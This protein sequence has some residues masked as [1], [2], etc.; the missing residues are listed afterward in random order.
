[1]LGA[2]G[3]LLAHAADRPPWADA[4]CGPLWVKPHAGGEG[5]TRMKIFVLL[6]S[7]IGV[8]LG[9]LW[10]LQG[11]GLL[12]VRPIL[13]FADCEPVQGPSSTWAIVGLLVVTGGILGV[14]YSLKHRARL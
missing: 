4:P 1:M 5:Q 7:V 10:L 2:E 9:G 12:Q 6:V 14:R 11:L 8:L 3:R 13:C